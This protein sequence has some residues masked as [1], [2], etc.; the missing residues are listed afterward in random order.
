MSVL[1]WK[2]WH[3]TELLTNSVGKLRQFCCVDVHRNE[4]LVPIAILHIHRIRIINDTGLSH[5][6][7]RVKYTT[8]LKTTM[9]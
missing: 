3:P 9:I 6:K 2:K 8:F 7:L 4:S 5:Y 1:M